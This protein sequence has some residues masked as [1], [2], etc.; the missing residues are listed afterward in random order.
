MRRQG[1]IVDW[2]TNNHATIY[3]EFVAEQQDLPST[4]ISPDQNKSSH[5]DLTII[6]DNLLVDMVAWSIHPGE[7]LSDHEYITWQISTITP[8]M[9][10]HT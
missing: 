3:N 8:Q 4:M 2:A 9:P 1:L 5:I 10:K 6:S 7:S